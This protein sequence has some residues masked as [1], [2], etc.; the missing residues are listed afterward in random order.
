MASSIQ[1]FRE[2]AVAQGSNIGNPT[3]NTYKGE[4][5]SLVQQY[6]YQVFGIPY[7][8]RGH[9]KDFVPPD[10]TKTSG[11]PKAGDIL[12]YQLGKGGAGKL[13][14]I[15]LVDDDGKFLN[16]NHN[17]DHKVYRDNVPA[18]Y[19]IFRPTKGF[20]IKNPTRS[21]KVYGTSYINND[22][23]V[24]KIAAFMYKTFSS[25]TKKAA[26]G[27]YFGPNLTAAIK[28][29]QKQTGLKNDGNV[30]PITMAKL[31][32]YGFKG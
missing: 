1:S 5:V 6:L 12:R 14:H 13:G 4:C 31:K 10:F 25:Y 3:V 17:G 20:T 26:L 21:V 32:S 7:K 30:G 19:E 24:G 22:P 15:G 16:Q 2:W 11:S 28:E 27:N 8:A 29:F 18:G 9:A 23:M